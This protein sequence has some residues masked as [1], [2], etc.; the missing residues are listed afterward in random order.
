MPES[1]KNS[2]LTILL[3]QAQTVLTV[4]YLVMVGVGM[5]YYHQK[6]SEFDINIFQYANIFYFLIAPFEDVFIL[7]L[8]A[9]AVV[10]FL[11]GYALDGVIQKKMPRFYSVMSFGT[12]KLSWFKKAQTASWML[13]FV[14]LLIVY[15]QI[16]GDRAKESVLESE[17][18]SIEFSDGQS[19]RGKMIGKTDST[20]FL[21]SGSVVKAIPLNSEV[22]EIVI[23]TS[24]SPL[25]EEE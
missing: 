2:T 16:Y 4:V 15:S 1:V 22:K 12:D 19:M 7:F 6:Y 3:K 23:T 17:P 13:T 8:C 20:L 25:E 24:F 5:L 21:L 10:L 18:I 11:A 14:L 9:V